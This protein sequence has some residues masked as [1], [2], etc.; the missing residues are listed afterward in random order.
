ML[1]IC[2]MQVYSECPVYDELIP[3]LLEVAAGNLPMQ[4][5][6]PSCSHILYDIYDVC[7]HIH[8]MQSA[9]R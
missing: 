8:V 6:N 2:L 3:A 1:C 4:V 9:S 5:L 7:I